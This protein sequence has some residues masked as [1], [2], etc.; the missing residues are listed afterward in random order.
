MLSRARVI[1][2]HHG[3]RTRWIG[4]RFRLLQRLDRLDRGAKTLAVA[5]VVGGALVAAVY[6]WL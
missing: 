5:A 1:G 6:V 3:L 4:V 2:S